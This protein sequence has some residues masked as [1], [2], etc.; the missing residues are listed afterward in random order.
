MFASIAP[1][2]SDRSSA[3]FAGLIAEFC[4]G[5]IRRH[6]AILLTEEELED[7]RVP[8]DHPLAEV[9]QALFPQY[10]D[11]VLASYFQN[12]GGKVSIED[13]RALADLDQATKKR[14]TFLF[15]P[16]GATG[17]SFVAVMED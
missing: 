11:P 13:A 6:F 8:D 3:A 9:V 5:A 14:S 12:A 10:H 7:F 2:L 17:W 16:V 4:H 1:S 15:T